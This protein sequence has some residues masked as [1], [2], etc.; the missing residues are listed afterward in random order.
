VPAKDKRQPIIV[1]H[2][3][4]NSLHNFSAEELPHEVSPTFHAGTRQAA[5][6]RIRDTIPR[7]L[8]NSQETIYKY[9]I[10]PKDLSILRYTDPIYRAEWVD[11]PTYVKDA[12]TPQLDVEGLYIQSDPG[13][14]IKPY[15][16]LAEDRGSTSYRIPSKLVTLGKVRHLGIQF[17]GY[18]P[19]IEDP[20]SNVQAVEETIGKDDQWWE[21]K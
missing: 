10:H 8:K 16:N 7:D 4:W 12:L 15:T 6:D 19:D 2:G 13:N 9:E 3:R 11:D 14:K 1:Y 17:R 18:N 20:K 5:L 21:Y